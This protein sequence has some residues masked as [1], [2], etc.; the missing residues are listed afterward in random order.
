MPT[1]IKSS[2]SARQGLLS[3]KAFLV[4]LVAVSLA[5][6]WIVWPFFGAVLWATVLAILFSPLYRRLLGR[7]R[8]RRTLAA[9]ATVLIILVM[10][11]LP[12]ALIGAMLLHEASACTAECSRAS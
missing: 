3:D 5:F 12:S 6:A 7:M 8:Q 1:P 10:V 11:I 2:E 9:L 4:L